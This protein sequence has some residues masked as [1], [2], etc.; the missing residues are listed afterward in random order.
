MTTKSPESRNMFLM[1][2]NKL[3]R[4]KHNWFLISLELIVTVIKM[5]IYTIVF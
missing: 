3:T 4:V 5:L 2:I 1:T